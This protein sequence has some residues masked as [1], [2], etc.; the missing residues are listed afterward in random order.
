MCERACHP[1]PRVFH[2]A[3]CLCFQKELL[4][5]LEES[6]LT[7]FALGSHTRS[8]GVVS[9]DRPFPDDAW[10]WRLR[11]WHAFFWRTSITCNG[12]VC[13][14]EPCSLRVNGQQERRGWSFGTLSFLFL[15]SPAAFYPGHSSTGIVRPLLGTGGIN[16]A[17]SVTSRFSF[18]AISTR[19]FGTGRPTNGDLLKMH[20]ES[21]T[22]EQKKAPL[23]R[24]WLTYA[25]SLPTRKVK[26]STMVLHEQPF[27]AKPESL[28]RL[29]LELKE[30]T[31]IARDAIHYLCAP[32]GSGKSATV[33]PVFL[34]PDADFTHL[35]YIAFRNNDGKFFQADPF[36]PPGGPAANSILAEE[37]GGAFAVD[38]LR[39]LLTEPWTTSG[40]RKIPLREVPGNP[41][42]AKEEVEALLEEHCG[43]DCKVLLHVDEHRDM[44]DREE[45]PRCGARFSYGAMSAWQQA[46]NVTVIATYTDRP[47]AVPSE[48][49]STVCRVPLALP[50]F[51]PDAAAKDLP[52]LKVPSSTDP[53]HDEQR[54]QATLRFRLAM[55]LRIVG[56]M[57]LH[58]HL[59]REEDLVLAPFL[60]EF[61]EAANSDENVKKRLESC[62][63]ICAVDD[64][65]TGD[66]QKD[67]AS[68]LLLGLKDGSE[69]LEQSRVSGL[70]VLPNRKLS[71]S[72]VDLLGYRDPKHAVY[73]RG[74]NRMAKVLKAPR[75]ALDGTP[76]EE[77]YA[78][79]LA[80]RSAVCETLDLG[81]S[82]FEAK[83]ASIK[84]GRI[85]STKDDKAVDWK[86]VQNMRDDTL[87]VA[88]EHG[89]PGVTGS[90]ALDTHPR[91][92]IFFLTAM[93]QLVLIDVTGSCRPNAVRSKLEKLTSAVMMLQKD[94]ERGGVREVHGVVLAPFVSKEKGRVC[95][96]GKEGLVCDDGRVELVCGEDAKYLLGGLAQVGEWFREDE[97]RD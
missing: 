72:L 84:L 15:A 29:A 2:M 19:W 61:K 62:I 24:D 67:I 78:W 54:L 16:A 12:Y 21:M 44:C 11:A 20:F 82:S 43:K 55:K 34:H 86:F 26:D 96:D 80:V 49:S 4:I 57:Y 73:L 79:V 74:A 51:D 64:V 89:R 14:Y 94:M 37:Q 65:E 23:F 56:L 47:L 58:R 71:A 13:Q 17:C 90:E 22:E 31:T 41:D 30:P 88:K 76:L 69:E 10:W 50:T 92:D 42:K 32:P 95:N 1:A 75:S 97:K 91:T 38:L 83:F 93:G 81:R 48:Q 8:D 46:K 9:P 59:R 66:Q 6:L 68:S 28:G 25:A 27:W 53:S 85:Y 3:W 70:V 45:H 7:S 52:E 77:A 60:K 39:S 18:G 87:Y 35:L 33:V 40:R 36:D 63:K 5:S